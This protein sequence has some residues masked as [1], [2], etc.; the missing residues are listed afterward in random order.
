M[1]KSSC[2]IKKSVYRILALSLYCCLS[3]QAYAKPDIQPLGENIADQGSQFYQFQIKEF[4][5]EDKNRTYRVWL[6]IPKNKQSV[7]ALP[8]V[9]MLDGNSV[10]DRLNEP[11]LKHLNKSS[12]PVLVAIGYKS[13]LPFETKSRSLDY[14]PADESGKPKADPRNPERLSGGSQ[15][16]R[17]L[18]AT[19]IMPW[20]EA[21]V[22]LDPSRK[23]LW[24]HSYG[25]LFVLDSLLHGHDF[26]HYIAA[27]PSLSWANKRILNI[28]EKTPSDLV[29]NKNLMIMEGDIPTHNVKH[30]SPNIDKEMI[31]NNRK[32]VS[33]LQKKGVNVRLMIYP[34]LSHGEVF[35]VS[36]LDTLSNQLF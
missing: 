13:N 6:G 27:S 34:N 16:F 11:F 4:Q 18:I 28:Q 17:V 36:M 35:Q 15:A 9:F 19:Q 23:V 1:F 12:S 32:L 20:V 7:Q 5:S 14:T 8:S 3:M 33:D 21:Q 29:R 22:K 2:L 30:L 24:G 31:N 26:S 10:M 25:G